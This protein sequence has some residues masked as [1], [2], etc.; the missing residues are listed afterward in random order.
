MSKCYFIGYLLR[1][2]MAISKG[3]TAMSIGTMLVISSSAL[4]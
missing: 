1:G 3:L 4:F 2:T